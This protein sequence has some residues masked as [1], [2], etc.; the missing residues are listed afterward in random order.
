MTVTLCELKADYGPYAQDVNIYY[1]AKTFESPMYELEHM[2]YCEEWL[3]SGLITLTFGFE[4][5]DGV[6]PIPTCLKVE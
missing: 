3:D 4:A 1:M 2:I 6:T 5:T